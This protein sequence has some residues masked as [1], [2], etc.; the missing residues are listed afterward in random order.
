MKYIRSS[1]SLLCCWL[2]DLWVYRANSIGDRFMTDS[3]TFTQ[4]QL[5]IASLER[6]NQRLK[7]ENTQLKELTLL[8]PLTGIANKRYL[9]QVLEQEYKNA[10]RSQE[11]LGILVIDLDRFK[12]Y[13]DTYGHLAGD[14]LLLKVATM[15]QQELRR[16]KDMLFRF[17]GEE[18][19]CI[20][21]N[22]SLS[23]VTKVGS[24]LLAAARNCGTTISV[25]AIC[26]DVAQLQYPLQLLEIADR[27][28]YQAKKQGRDCLVAIN[29][30]DLG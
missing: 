15:L 30:I 4:L 11:P 17:G 25:G 23:G 29:K 3:D 21:P 16:P 1:Q 28:M 12:Q 20:L 27:A 19:T 8:D 22:T 24:K 2:S 18:F 5:Q 9:E 26:V 14:R 10:L 7:Q 13:N 6:E